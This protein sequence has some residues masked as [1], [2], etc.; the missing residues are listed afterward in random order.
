MVELLT[1]REV[2][3]M[4]RL[5]EMTI[6][7]Y[8]RSGR[9]EAVRIGRRLR[10]RPEAVE[11]LLQPIEIAGPRP[12]AEKKE[13]YLKEGDSIFNIIGIMEEAPENLSEDKYAYLGNVPGRDD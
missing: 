13:H 7:R 11:K 5:H 9:L 12:V 3:Q 2:A 1:V 4:T 8:I 6:W 10:V